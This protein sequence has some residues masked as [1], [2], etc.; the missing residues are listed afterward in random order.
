MGI[1][2]PLGQFSCSRCGRCKLN[3]APPRYRSPIILQSYSLYGNERVASSSGMRKLQFVW[4]LPEGAC[5]V[6]FVLLLLSV[7]CSRADRSQWRIRLSRV[8]CEADSFCAHPDLASSTR[9]VDS[10]GEHR[11][12]D[13]PASSY[14]D[15]AKR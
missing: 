15:I 8:S 7:L 4:A 5:P 6:V 3:C 12:S 9:Y 1:S 10:V 14:L 2:F 13:R 11:F